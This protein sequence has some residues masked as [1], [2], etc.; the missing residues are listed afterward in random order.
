MLHDTLEDTDTEYEELEQEFN[1]DVAQYVLELTHDIKDKSKKGEILA[2]K[3]NHMSTGALLIKLADR[4]KNV[5]DFDTADP[6]F[7]ARYKPE[8]EYILDNLKTPHLK[9]P[10]R[11]LVDAIRKA[12]EPF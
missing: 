9:E 10:H 4:L 3:M 6:K 11:R 7:V 5:S 8:T 12:I 1:R 2:D